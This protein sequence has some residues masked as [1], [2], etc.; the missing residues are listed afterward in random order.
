MILSAPGQVLESFHSVDDNNKLAP[1]MGCQ[2]AE[3]DQ[4]QVPDGSFPAFSASSLIVDVYVSY[5]RQQKQ[6]CVRKYGNGRP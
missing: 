3:A 6:Q 1:S 4:K 2:P 5:R